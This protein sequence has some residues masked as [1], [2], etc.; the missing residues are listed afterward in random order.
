M[1][2]S[3]LCHRVQGESVPNKNPDVSERPSFIPPLRDS[4]EKT[5]MLGGGQEEKGSTEDEMAG[6]HLDGPEFE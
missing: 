1:E 4:L 2:Y 6:W 3:L 5:L